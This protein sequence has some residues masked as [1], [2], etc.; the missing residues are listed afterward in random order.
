MTAELR[1]YQ[2]HNCPGCGEDRSHPVNLG[3][4]PLR[5]CDR[6]SVVYAPQY[7]DPSEVYVE[8]YLFGET[9]FGLDLMHPIFQAFLAQAAATRLRLIEKVVGPN[10]SFLDVGCGTG[11]LLAVARA[12]GWTTTG[13]EPVSQSAEYAIQQRGLQVIPD[14]LERS[15]LPEHSFDVVSAFHVVEHMIDAQ[16]FLRTLSRWAKPG[17]HVVVEVPNWRSFH[18]RNAGP[19]WEGLRPLEHL[20]HYGPETLKATMRRAGLR[21]VL[22]RTPT[23]L[24]ARQTLDHRLDA[25]GLYKWKGRSRPQRVFGRPGQ[26]KGEAV[27]V[28]RRLTALAL[29][30]L[31]ATYERLGVGQVVLAIAEVPPPTSEPS[32]RS[33]GDPSATQ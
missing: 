11:E 3:D 20:G 33:A 30:G 26:L 19:G 5:R 15:G 16:S 12:R 27:I 25:L 7:A 14:L 13:V 9:P 17:G 29:A 32:A 21:P 2:V 18:R 22:V 4:P 10:A 1:A 8:G 31:G 28:P 23:F 24:W 6:C